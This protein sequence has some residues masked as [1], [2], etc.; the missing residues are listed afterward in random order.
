ME[1]KTIT[2]SPPVTA[3]FVREDERRTKTVDKEASEPYC[4]Y[5]STVDVNIHDNLRARDA[6]SDDFDENAA[7]NN[8]RSDEEGRRANGDDD[9]DVDDGA[10]PV[11]VPQAII[12]PPVDELYEFEDILGEGA[13]STVVLGE[14]QPNG[15]KWAIKIIDKARLDTEQRRQRA[16]TEINILTQCSHPNIMRIESIHESK[17]DVC[18]VLPLYDF[19]S[20]YLFFKYHFL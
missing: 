1:T 20:F 4:Q 10:W 5:T 13:F 12:R 9:A 3:S 16:L 15:G 19:S 6:D 18:L 8:A 7:L 11:L 2:S 14:R 17:L